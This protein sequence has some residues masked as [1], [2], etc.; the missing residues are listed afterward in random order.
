MQQSTKFISLDLH[1]D[2]LFNDMLTCEAIQVTKY[3]LSLAMYLDSPFSFHVPLSV[4]L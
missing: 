2:A 4:Q 1:T 3:F